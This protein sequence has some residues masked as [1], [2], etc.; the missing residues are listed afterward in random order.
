MTK[1]GMRLNPKKQYRSDTVIAN[2]TRW[3]RAEQS[4][5]LRSLVATGSKVE[6]GDTI[7]YINDPLGENTA[8]LFSPTSGIVIGKTNLP[9]VFAGEA[10]FNI[11]SFEESDATISGHI[12]AYQEEL[13]PGDGDVIDDDERPLM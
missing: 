13:S 9:L 8:P 12:E 4:G 3:V 5:I 11:A 7:A 1:L 10:V 2:T 6:K